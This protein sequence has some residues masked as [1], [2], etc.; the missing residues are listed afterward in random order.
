MQPYEQFEKRWSKVTGKSHV[1]GCASGAA[2]LHL[3]LEALNLPKGSQVIVPEFTM[4][5]CAR[6]VDM[7]GLMPIFADCQENLCI[8]PESVRLKITK[9]TKAIMPVHIYGRRC[10]M[11]AI[12]ELADKHGLYVIEDCAEF[13][14][15]PLAP[16]PAD[17]SCWSFYKNKIIAGEEGGAVAFNGRRRASC[18]LAKRARALR[19]YAFDECHNF[20]HGPR[21]WNYRLSNAHALL[22]MD[23]MQFIPRKLRRRQRVALWYDELVDPSMR[24]P[25]RDVVWVYDVRIDGLR[26][27]DIERLVDGLRQQGV[28]ARCGFKPM[29]MQP[30]YRER[31]GDAYKQTRAYRLSQQILY[32]PVHPEMT[33]QTVE[34]NV[35][36]LNHLVTEL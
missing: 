5:A 34:R 22:I 28:E 21:G 12:R 13:H 1:V 33:R 24:M 14:G 2:A 35:E 27:G 9:L 26:P 3:G 10:D 6:A 23:N 30:E 19:S 17:V 8:D 25:P 4:I 15:G 18:E 7:A 31:F 20:M 11:R 29:S 16:Y 32:L 36:L